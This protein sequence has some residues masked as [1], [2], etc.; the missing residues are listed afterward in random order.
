[1]GQHRPIQCTPI[2]SEMENSV[3]L[4]CTVLALAA[5]TWHLNTSMLQVKW[6]EL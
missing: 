2:L 4:Y 1:M 6:Q 5:E 3:C